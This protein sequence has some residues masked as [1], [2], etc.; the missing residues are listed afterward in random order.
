M[1][2]SSVRLIVPSL[3]LMHAYSGA[4]ILQRDLRYIF[5]F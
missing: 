3:S 2:F 5:T 4:N 1:W